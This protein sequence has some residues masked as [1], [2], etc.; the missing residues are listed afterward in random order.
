M[1]V[2]LDGQVASCVV[3]GND[4]HNAHPSPL[5]LMVI[6]LVREPDLWVGLANIDESP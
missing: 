4:W 6:G 1:I 3:I 5:G 2:D